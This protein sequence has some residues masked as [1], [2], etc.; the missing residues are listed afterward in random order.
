MRGEEALVTILM[1][2]PC[3]ATLTVPASLWASLC[4]CE[5]RALS[6]PNTKRGCAGHL[7]L[8]RLMIPLGS[9][10]GP[11]PLHPHSGTQALG[12][13]G[14]WSQALTYIKCPCVLHCWAP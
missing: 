11:H 2:L 6:C 5:V 14:D 12:G 3:W 10:L 13:S 7:G 8:G 4:I 1:L 9:S